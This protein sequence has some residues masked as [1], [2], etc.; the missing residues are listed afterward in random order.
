MSVLPRDTMRKR[1]RPVYPTRSCIVSRRLKISSNFFLGPV[2]LSFYYLDSERG[3]QIPRETP[4]AGALNTRGRKNC[5]FRLKSPFI[6]ETIQDR[7]IYGALIGSHRWR[8]D[9]CRFRWP[10][11]SLKGRT[12]WVKFF[13]R[14]SLIRLRPFDLQRRNSAR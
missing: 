1:G 5:Y 13:R 9:Q 3:Y 8:I 12:K 2:A 4:S 6:S 14:L 10:W 11:V 7:P